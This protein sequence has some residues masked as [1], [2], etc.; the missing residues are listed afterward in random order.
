MNEND[1]NFKTES[2]NSYIDYW[3]EEV[4]DEKI[5]LN[6][7]FEITNE[8][9]GEWISDSGINGYVIHELE[10]KLKNKEYDGSDLNDDCY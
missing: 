6:D 5:E 1:F 3:V 8:I 2:L 7:L 9:V 4:K 10:E